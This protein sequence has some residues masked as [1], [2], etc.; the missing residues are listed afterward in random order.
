MVTAYLGL[1]SNLGDRAQALVDAVERLDRSDE[2]AV[3]RVAPFFETAPI[4]LTEQPPFIN[5]VV[6]IETRLEPGELLRRIK[7]IEAD[8]GRTPTARWGP[9]LID[10][11][12]LLYGGLQLQTVRLT[13]PHPEMWRRAFVLAPLAALRP[14]LRTLNGQPISEVLGELMRDQHVR[15]YDAPTVPVHP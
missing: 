11:D 4:G 5:S 1:G 8:M 14:D 10:I 7:A 9:R 15:P 6:E 12:L 3:T 2:V 13:L